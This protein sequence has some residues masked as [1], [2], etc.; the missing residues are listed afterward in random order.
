M[1][2]RTQRVTI[3]S[4]AAAFTLVA[5]AC[6]SSS[7][8]SSAG[9]SSSS[10]SSKAPISVGLLLGLSSPLSASVKS[11]EQGILYEIKQVN[12]AGG[13]NGRQIKYYVLD[14]AGTTWDPLEST[15][16]HASLSIL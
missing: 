12:A 9:G 13:I 7:S 16:R 8:S 5:A 11:I 10:S 6:S 3:L 1:A 2:R 15:C 14:D 4:L